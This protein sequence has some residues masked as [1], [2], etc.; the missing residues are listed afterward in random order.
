MDVAAG[1][2]N[3]GLNV[4]PAAGLGL[5]AG[6]LEV[7]AFGV[8]ITNSGADLAIDAVASADS[9]S[10]F[11]QESRRSLSETRAAVSQAIE[12]VVENPRGVAA[13]VVDSVAHTARGF[14][15]GDNRAV[16]QAFQMTFDAV[17]GGK[18]GAHGARITGEVVETSAQ[19]LG[20]LAHLVEGATYDVIANMGR[21]PQVPARRVFDASET[22]DLTRRALAG[23]GNRNAAWQLINEGQVSGLQ[24]NS[25]GR[26]I[27]S[28]TK[29]FVSYAE[30]QKRAAQ[31][32]GVA[33]MLDRVMLIERLRLG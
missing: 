27:D 8:A 21:S 24:M 1:M 32:G 15:D 30:A 22:A 4:F 23:A 13:A 25:L 14:K 28:S 19:Q 33:R 7:L 20:T 31:P 2:E 16:A 6:L 5:G 11:V 26:P 29:R 9:E 3:N 18:G 12:T 10:F 17:A